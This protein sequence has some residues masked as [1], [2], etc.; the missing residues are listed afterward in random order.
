[1]QYQYQSKELYQDGKDPNYRFD[2]QQDRGKRQFKDENEL[3][4]PINDPIDGVM[5]SDE[6]KNRAPVLS[7]RIL[8]GLKEMIGQ[9]LIINAQG[10]ANSKRNKKD[11]CTIIGSLDTN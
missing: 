8:E 6:E 10:L 3:I 7:V 4:A 5:I 1:M 11:G 9:N 2:M